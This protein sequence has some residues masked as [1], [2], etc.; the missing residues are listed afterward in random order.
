M[1]Y[2]TINDPDEAIPIKDAKGKHCQICV[3]ANLS[4]DSINDDALV[5]DPT[6]ESKIVVLD[7]KNKP[8]ETKSDNYTHVKAKIPP[9]KLKTAFFWICGI[10]NMTGDNENA[11]QQASEV[12]DTSIDQEPFWATFCDLNAIIAVGLSCFCFAFFNKFDS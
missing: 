11:V 3:G 12:I 6:Q 4:E 10:E 5:F 7:G 8:E 2:F 9:G 1:T